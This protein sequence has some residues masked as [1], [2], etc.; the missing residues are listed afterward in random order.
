MCCSVVVLMCCSVDVTRNSQPRNSQPATRNPQL[1]NS[2]PATRNPQPATRQLATRLA[3]NY[4][5]HF[6]QQKEDHQ[7]NPKPIQKMPIHRQ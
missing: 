3:Q 1:A 6:H 2:Q 4:P 5:N 7:I